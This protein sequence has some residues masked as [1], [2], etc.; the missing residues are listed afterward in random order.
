MLRSP[1]WFGVIQEF[2]E[3]AVI[4][5]PILLI[6]LLLLYGLYKPLSRL[7]Y[8]VG[9]FMVFVLE[10]ILATVMYWFSG[11]ASDNLEA[12][13]IFRYWVLCLTVTGVL[14]AYFNL[15]SRALSPAFTEARLQA[16]QSRIRPHFLFNCINAV[17]S[18]IR[19]DPKRAEHALEDMA[20]LF[21]VLMA[22]NR[23][24]SPLQQEIKLCRQYLQLEQLR[25]GERLKV[26]WHIDNLPS[27]ALIPPLVL[28]PLLENAVYHGIEP[29]VGT[30]IININIYKSRDEVHLVLR[31]PFQ[32]EGK[33]HSG[34]KMALNNIRERLALHFDAESRLEN[35]VSDGVYQV[36][37]IIPFVT[38]V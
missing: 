25:L 30:G 33:H 31:N 11:M 9:I 4:T 5:Q 6:N 3:I 28:Q 20:D 29:I 8:A 7:S 14:L 27:D 38:T 35:R 37:I 24:L 18:L 16:L 34:N 10:L 12:G 1:T 15:R 19:A 2:T 22:D 13:M 21:R 32:A 36:H 23:Q 17:L 26:E